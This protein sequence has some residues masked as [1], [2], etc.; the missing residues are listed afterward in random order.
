M[1]CEVLHVV[2]YCGNWD[3]VIHDAAA[4]LMYKLTQW[5]W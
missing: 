1:L 5:F 4:V 3:I 2:V